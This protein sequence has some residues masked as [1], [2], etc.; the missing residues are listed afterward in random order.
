MNRTKA[1]ALITNLI[2][3]TNNGKLMKVNIPFPARDMV[4]DLIDEGLLARATFM[5][6][7]DS[8]RLA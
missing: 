7:G 5:K 4:N 6:P 8:V 1:L 3:C 2:A